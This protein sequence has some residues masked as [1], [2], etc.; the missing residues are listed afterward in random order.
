MIKNEQ[1][2]H[3]VCQGQTFLDV[4]PAEFIGMEIVGSNFY[5][6]GDQRQVF[7]DGSTDMIFTNCNTDNVILPPNST[8]YGTT[9]NKRIHK[10][11]NGVDYF[12]DESTGAPTEALPKEV[13]ILLGL[14]VDVKDLP[15]TELEKDVITAKL[16]ELAEA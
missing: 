16:E 11:T 13:M 8:L 1:Y 2:S 14:S 9:T 3:Q 5:Q 12:C 10:Q 15:E 4:D 6:E 7:P